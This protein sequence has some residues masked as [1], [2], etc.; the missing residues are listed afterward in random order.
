MAC[1]CSARHA[2][3]LRVYC[4]EYGA[5]QT[6][7]KP[8]ERP[9]WEEDMTHPLLVHEVGKCIRCSLC[10][11][12]S[13]HKEEP[14]GLAAVGRGSSKRP[15]PPHGS[16]WADALTISPEEYAASCPTG[17][18]SVHRKTVRK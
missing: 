18:I 14:I 10:I 8:A 11:R 17:A 15:G 5:K 9:P 7:F 13:V 3:D 16:T 2:C 12:L 1:D 4:D 6:R